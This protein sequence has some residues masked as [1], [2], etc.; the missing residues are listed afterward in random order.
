MG[1]HLQVP[2]SSSVRIWRGSRSP[3]VRPL[4]CIPRSSYTGKPFQANGAA[5][6]TGWSPLQKHRTSRWPEVVAP[7]DGRSSSSSQIRFNC[8]RAC[9]VCLQEKSALD[10][11]SIIAWLSPASVQCRSILSVGDP[12]LVLADLTDGDIDMSCLVQLPFLSPDSSTRS[13]KSPPSLPR[14]HP[15][16]TPAGFQPLLQ[17]LLCICH[18]HTQTRTQRGWHQ[19]SVIECF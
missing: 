7:E 17:A 10:S 13:V 5:Q 4:P 1:L 19:S 18:S 6:E 3:E 8:S 12:K 2:L 15:P 16:S 14:P 9:L 11:L